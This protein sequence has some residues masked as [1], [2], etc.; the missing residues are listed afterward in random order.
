[1]RRGHGQVTPEEFIEELRKK[2]NI[3]V[4]IGPPMA[5]ALPWDVPYETIANGHLCKEGELDEPFGPPTI[6]DIEAKLAEAN[7]WGIWERTQSGAYKAVVI[8][9]GVAFKV[10]Q[11][12]EDFFDRKYSPARIVARTRI[13]FIPGKLEDSAP[14]ETVIGFANGRPTYELRVATNGRYF[15]FEKCIPFE[16]WSNPLVIVNGETEFASDASAKAIVAKFERW[17]RTGN[18]EYDQEL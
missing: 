17:L 3:P 18:F 8:R 14:E 5:R 4:L 13:A 1:M 6:P 10:D 12:P 16:D 2:L 11:Y 7:L 15:K 9:T